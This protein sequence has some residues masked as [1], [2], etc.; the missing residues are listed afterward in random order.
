[1]ATSSSLVLGLG[2]LVD[3][4]NLQQEQKQIP[5]QS[6]SSP[7]NDASTSRTP[8]SSIKR[9][10]LTVFQV[11]V[12]LNTRETSATTSCHHLTAAKPHLLLT[13]YDQNIR[14]TRSGRTVASDL[15]SVAE[16][17]HPKRPDSGGKVTE[18][19]V[20]AETAP[21]PGRVKRSGQPNATVKHA[22]DTLDNYVLIEL[23]CAFLSH[24][25]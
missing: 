5:T 24:L 15:F 22:G 18:F 16:S 4:Q 25:S 13:R 3:R 9:N 10:G 7:N 1:M 23:I 2:K 21:M 6:R 17:V 8:T 11:A 12:I 14:S 19:R 20:F